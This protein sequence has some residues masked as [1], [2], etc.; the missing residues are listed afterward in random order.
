M[1]TVL[2][3]DAVHAAL[4]KMSVEKGIF[5]GR[6]TNDMLKAAIL[7]YKNQSKKTKKSK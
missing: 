3:E 6:I 5:I 7:E 1:R 4:K 2:L